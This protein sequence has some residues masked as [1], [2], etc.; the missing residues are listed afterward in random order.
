MPQLIV[1]SPQRFKK[2]PKS[3]AW[4]AKYA[5]EPD[6]VLADCFFRLVET[7]SGLI[8][9]DIFKQF[10]TVVGII[11]GTVPP[12][13]PLYASKISSILHSSMVVCCFFRHCVLASSRT[14]HVFPERI[15]SGEN[16]SS[17]DVEGALSK[18]AKTTGGGLGKKEFEAVL[19]TLAQKRFRAPIEGESA[20]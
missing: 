7:T 8:S 18:I 6:T 11:D 3:E 10:A 15:Q 9:Q 4:Y 17:E 20:D 14:I 5:L 1:E 16:I 2:E 12:S 13:D 19:D